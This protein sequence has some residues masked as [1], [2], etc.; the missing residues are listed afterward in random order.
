MQASPPWTILP[1]YPPDYPDTDVVDR[2][3]SAKKDYDDI[4]AEPPAGGYTK[5]RGK[6]TK[7]RSDD[8]KKRLK[9]AKRVLQLLKPVQTVSPLPP[10]V[11]TY[12][13]ADNR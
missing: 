10:G 4:A 7:L 6:S 5:V 8:Q 11:L 3:T 2:F 12:G 9:K 13:E 1:E